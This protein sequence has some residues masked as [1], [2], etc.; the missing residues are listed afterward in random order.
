[1]CALCAVWISHLF[2]HL[3]FS[4]WARSM[5]IMRISLSVD[6]TFMCCTRVAHHSLVLA[7]T[8]THAIRLLFYQMQY[9]NAVL[10]HFFSFKM[11]SSSSYS[12]RCRSLL[13]DFGWMLPL[14]RYWFIKVIQ[15]AFFSTICIALLILLL[16]V[17]MMPHRVCCSHKVGVMYLSLVRLSFV[18]CF[19]HVQYFLYA[20]SFSIWSTRSL[21]QHWLREYFS[22]STLSFFSSSSSSTNKSIWNTVQRLLFLHPHKRNN[23]SNTREKREREAKKY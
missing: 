8:S 19:V 17:L 20:R 6:T 7:G 1:M 13:F 23:N 21:T 22:P 12:A 2:L 4:Y 11:I 14:P 15:H 18:L 16:P 3:F 9:V 5:V 10:W